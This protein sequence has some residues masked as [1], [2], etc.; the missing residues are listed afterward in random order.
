GH[1]TAPVYLAPP[2]LPP[3]RSGRRKVWIAAGIAWVL[4][5]AVVLAFVVPPVWR[6]VRQ[7]AA[8]SL[9]PAG[10]A[11]GPYLPNTDAQGDPT[12]V[13]V[14][15]HAPTPSTAPL[16]A[17]LTAAPSTD[18]PV[19]FAEAQAALQA[20]WPLRNAALKDGNGHLLA[21]IETGPA[22]EGDVGDC[23]TAG[24]GWGPIESSMMFVSSQQRSWPA[25]FVGE[26]ITTD[27]DGGSWVVT[28]HFTRASEA[29]PWMIDF[30][31]EYEPIGPPQLDLPYGGGAQGFMTPVYLATTLTATDL[32]GELAANWRAAKDHLPGT[33]SPDLASGAWTTQ[34]DGVLSQ[35]RQGQVNRSNGL[36]GHYAYAPDP[37]GSFT[38]FTP[39]A[40]VICGVVRVEKVWTPASGQIGVYQDPAQSNWG[41]GVPPGTYRAIIATT[42]AEPCFYVPFSPT[43]AGSVAV[44]GGSEQQYT[45][46]PIS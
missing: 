11:R 39:Y 5:A 44:A 26:A 29:V 4:F 13:N 23:C 40:T 17:A 37:A 8:S 22:L 46:L 33:A 31:S 25:E 1:P 35:Y 32:L 42:L 9:P 2:P 24:N 34:F 18:V 10:L 20:V 14:A 45:D 6:G 38:F 21:E 19:T 15:F 36:A 7:A 30:A 27:I 16:P 3:N 41:P 43:S 12:W 28:L